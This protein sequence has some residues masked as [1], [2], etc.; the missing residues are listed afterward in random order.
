MT[1]HKRLPCRNAVQ[2]D[3][4]GPHVLFRDIETRSKIGLQRKS[5][6]PGSG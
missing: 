6:R 5:G 1:M 3:I 4:T 2:A